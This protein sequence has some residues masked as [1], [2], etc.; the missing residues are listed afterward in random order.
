MDCSG[1]YWKTELKSGFWKSNEKFEIYFKGTYI[2][3]VGQKR[4]L[5]WR[6]RRK[7]R[8]EAGLVKPHGKFWGPNLTLGIINSTVLV[9]MEC[10][11]IQNMGVHELQ[12]GA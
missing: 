8:L 1:S 2:L 5:N 12:A 10:V 3:R 6:P 7:V 11:V 4:G 9:K